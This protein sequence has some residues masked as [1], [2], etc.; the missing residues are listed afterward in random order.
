MIGVFFF[1]TSFLITLVP[2]FILLGFDSISFHFCVQNFFATTSI[3]LW[4]VLNN[5]I[6]CC[7]PTLRQVWG[8]NSHSQ[9]W[10]LG[11]LQDSKTPV[12]LELNCRGQNTSPWDVLYTVG[13]ALK[14]KC[15]KW[16]RMSHLDICSTSYSRKKGREWQFDS[17]PQKVKNQHNPGVCR[18]IATHC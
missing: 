13:K 3:I 1:T 8:W 7:N 2:T 5:L 9:K 16:P 14:C 12:I 17:Q 6:R 10:E 18:W 4:N 15:R 11:V